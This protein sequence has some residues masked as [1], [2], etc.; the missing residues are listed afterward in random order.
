[1]V[2]P[3][4]PES[5]EQVFDDM[6]R[7]AIPTFTQFKFRFYLAMPQDLRSGVALDDCYRLWASHSIEPARLAA[8]T[9]WPLPEIQT[10]ES[11]RGSST[12]HTFPTL[13]E[14]RC[15][16]HEHF[17]EAGMILPSYPLGEHCPILI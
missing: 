13:A 10:V 17:D 15:L 1:Y 6:F 12:V 4:R 11:F 8:I 14:F 7:G 9:H 16:L 2:R 3:E 5:L